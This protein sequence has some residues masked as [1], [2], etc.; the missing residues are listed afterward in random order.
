[1]FLM[2]AAF[3][4]FVPVQLTDFYSGFLFWKTVLFTKI[5]T[6][7]TIKV[8]VLLTEKKTKKKKNTLHTFS[9]L[10]MSVNPKNISPCAEKSDEKF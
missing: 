10:K 8:L 2:L 4:S 1:M 6:Q 7:K 9:E 3:P 5:K